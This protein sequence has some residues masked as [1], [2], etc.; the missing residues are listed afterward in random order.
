MCLDCGCMKPN[1]EHGDN[2]HLTMKQVEDAAK[3]SDISVDE[4][5]KNIIKTMKEAT[6]GTS[7]KAA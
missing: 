3:A 6:S 7:K 2:R 1:D 4:A 5:V